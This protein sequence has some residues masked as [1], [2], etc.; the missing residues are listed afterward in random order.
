MQIQVRRPQLHRHPQMRERTDCTV[1]RLNPNPEKTVLYYPTAVD[2]VEGVIAKQKI[3][4][5]IYRLS[6]RF[7]FDPSGYVYTGIN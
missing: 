4:E 2:T 5:T 1:T 7:I 6:Y 3:H